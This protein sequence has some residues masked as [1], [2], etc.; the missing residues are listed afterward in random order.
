MP[1]ISR[2]PLVSSCVYGSLELVTS[3]VSNTTLSWFILDGLKSLSLSNLVFHFNLVHIYVHKH[4]RPENFVIQS[5]FILM[6]VLQAFQ[7]HMAVESR[8]NFCE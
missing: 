8:Y 5:C 7:F 3:T 6:G 1:V 2:H 4:S